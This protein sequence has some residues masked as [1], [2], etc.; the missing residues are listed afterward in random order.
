MI[1]ADQLGTVLCGAIS[2]PFGEGPCAPLIR[3]KDH[4]YAG[5]TGPER[6]RWSPHFGQ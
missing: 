5:P 4:R 2:Q 1:A 6:L 3:M